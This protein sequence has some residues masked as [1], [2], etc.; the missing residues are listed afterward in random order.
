MSFPSAASHNPVI[1]LK[2]FA[3][4]VTPGDLTQ[5]PLYQSEPENLSSFLVTAPSIPLIYQTPALK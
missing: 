1:L 4:S 5:L 2:V 3:V